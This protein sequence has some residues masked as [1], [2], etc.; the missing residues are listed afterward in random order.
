MKRILRGVLAAATIGLLGAASGMLTAQASSSQGSIYGNSSFKAGSY[1]VQVHSGANWYWSTCASGAAECSQLA[2]SEGIVYVV[3]TPNPKR[4]SMKVTDTF[5]AQGV[6]QSASISPGVQFT[7]LG[8]SCVSDTQEVVGSAGRFAS[9][10]AGTNCSYKVYVADICKATV[11]AT[12]GAL[13]GS[14]WY[15][16]NS[17]A[18]KSFCG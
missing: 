17:S 8:N 10:Y 7:K 6:P 9:T 2:A 5:A 3:S 12:G 14:T 16:G 15:H 13:Y 1:T 11:T 18:S 4:F